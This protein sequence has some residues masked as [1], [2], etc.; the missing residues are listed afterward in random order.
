MKNFFMPLLLIVVCSSPLAAFSQPIMSNKG[1]DRADLTKRP[2]QKFDPREIKVNLSNIRTQQS[3][4]FQSQIRLNSFHSLNIKQKTELVSCCFT[5]N[6]NG[7]IPPTMPLSYLAI[8]NSPLTTPKAFESQ[9]KGLAFITASQISALQPLGIDYGS[10]LSQS[11][12]DSV[13]SIQLPAQPSAD[14][15]RTDV[16]AN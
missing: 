12:V 9:V 13:V 4:M 5:T 1:G 8:S 3:L 2:P 16:T 15:N 11:I 6:S 14:Q 7:V 10:L